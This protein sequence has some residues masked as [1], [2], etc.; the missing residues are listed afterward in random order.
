[1]KNSNVALG[2]SKLSVLQLLAT[3]KLIVK[4]MTGNTSFPAPDPP[5]ADITTAANKLQGSSDEVAQAKKTLSQKV[6]LQT[7]D[8]L[9]LRAL[10]TAQGNYVDNR[11]K[12][13]KAIIESAGMSASE[14][15]G[16]VGMMPQV[17]GLA[18]TRGDNPGEVDAH[19]N[20]ISKRNNYIVQYTA[21][22]IDNS[23]WETKGN[24]TKSSF[25]IT[26]L[27]SGS[28]IW[29]RVCANATAGAG[30][31]SDPAFIVVP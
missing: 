29:V 28:K 10:L 2:L 15:G 16:P 21:D 7:T 11:A 8:E 1:M 27:V 24:P 25:T 18:T 20:P 9:A 3:A 17:D 4:K 22:P 5:L 19:W 26:E 6:S 14:Q 13:D 12:G 23:K 30:P 31:F